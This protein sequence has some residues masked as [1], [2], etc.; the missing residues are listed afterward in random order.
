[1]ARE[2]HST[3]RDEFRKQVRVLIAALTVL[4]LMFLVPL[5]GAVAGVWNG[6]TFAWPSDI[7]T[8]MGRVMRAPNHPASAYPDSMAG[9]IPGPLGYW[10]TVGVLELI[11]LTVA[12]ASLIV[13]VARQENYGMLTRRRLKQVMKGYTKQKVVM[14]PIGTYLGVPL[15][16][17]PNDA[18]LVVAPQ[19]S[20]KTT[21][22]AAPGVKDAPGAV[23]ASSTKVD[24]MSTTIYSRFDPEDPNDDR[25]VHVFDVDRISGWPQLTRW[26]MV[27]GC[28]EADVADGRAK[29]AIAAAPQSKGGGGGN[30]AFFAEQAAIVLAG[31]LHA[32]AISGKTMREVRTWAFDFDNDEPRLILENHPDAIPGWAHELTRATQGAARETTASTSMTLAGALRCLANPRV[33]EMVCPPSTDRRYAEDLSDTCFDIPRFVARNKDT[34]YLITLGGGEVSTAPLVTAF[35]AAVVREGRLFSQRQ[36][37]GKI[38]P[39]ATFI[40]DEAANA[41]PIPDLPTLLSDGG[42]RGQTTRAF[43]QAFSQGREKWGRDGFDGMWGATSMKMI[44]PGCTETDDLERVSRLIGDRKIRQESYSTQGWGSSMSRSSQL[45]TERIMPVDT[46]QQLDDFTGLCIYKNVGNAVIQVTPY[47]KRKDSK[48]FRDSQKRFES[49]SA[50]TQQPALAAV[51]VHRKAHT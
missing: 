28:E 48:D 47:W 15:R 41:A 44:L 4:V 19:Q 29:A 30:S 7:L 23:V 18:M 31:L 10:V 38:S 22:L 6:G 17:R 5:G 51:P 40:L 27:A 8:T 35:V 13:S 49:A 20:G 39:P 50:A 43:V 32:A 21:G 3:E 26:N 24:L 33:L 34:L 14:A 46:I 42:G 25:E 37:G 11:V 36:P 16:P 9:A 2:V 45:S 12:L 1:M